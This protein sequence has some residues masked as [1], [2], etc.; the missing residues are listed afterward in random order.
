MT[1]VVIMTDQITGLEMQDLREGRTK[2]SSWKMQ[3]RSALNPLM[4]PVIPARS[5]DRGPQTVLDSPDWRRARAR[6]SSASPS[7]SKQLVR[8]NAACPQPTA[9]LPRTATVSHHITPHHIKL[10]QLKSSGKF[11]MEIHLRTTGCHTA[12]PATRHKRTHPALTPA[13]EGWYSIY[14]PRRDG[15]LS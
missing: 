9:V 13:S 4:P 1:G 11:L 15:R 5:L 14:L 6:S 3:Y 7:G 10:K 2:L 8:R 12:L